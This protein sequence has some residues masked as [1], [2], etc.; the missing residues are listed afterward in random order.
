MYIQLKCRP[1]ESATWGNCP[2]LSATESKKEMYYCDI[3]SKGF[4]AEFCHSEVLYRPTF[5]RISRLQQL[6]EYIAHDM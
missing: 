6:R 2:L 1:I 5:L 3:V 4:T